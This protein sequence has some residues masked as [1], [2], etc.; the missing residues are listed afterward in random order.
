MRRLDVAILYALTVAGYPLVSAIPTFAGVDSHLASLIFRAIY[1]ALAVT[2]LIRNLRA[3][4]L[5][6]G[7]AWLP[8]G[9]FWILYTGR[10]VWDTQFSPLPHRLAG[11]EY[12]I[13]AFG[14]CLVPM[15]AFLAT[16]E[17]AT[18]DLAAT[19]SLLA[20]GLASVLAIYVSYIALTT[21]VSATYATGRLETET[22]NPVSLGH[23][24][25]STAILAAL[26]L[27][28][29][30]GAR[31]LFLLVTGVVGLFAVIASASR[32]PLLA[33]AVVGAVYLA[34]WMRNRAWQR[35]MAFSIGIVTLAT[36]LIWGAKT[37]Q[38]AF[39]L[40]T[41]DRIV[42]LHDLR[43]DESAEAHLDAVSSAWQEFL[44]RPL[45]G[46][47]ID[48]TRTSEYPHNVVVE[49]FMA[50]GVFG[51]LAFLALIALACLASINLLQS[52]ATQWVALLFVQYCVA[53]L[54]SGALY[55][56]GS[57]WCFAAA[58]IGLNAG[59]LRQSPSRKQKR[60]DVSPF[61]TVG[62]TAKNL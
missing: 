4:S 2:V 25:A 7:I 13:W 37:I 52:D 32:G 49:S 51:G 33:L 35:A 26:F 57:F 8:L 44:D 16:E 61:D 56:S 14:A 47:G 28:R 24:G 11:P 43:G 58:V 38:N 40:H 21:G 42:A 27:K 54:V 41:V 17:E 46:N 12:F 15:V 10:L 62:S 3:G 53:A 55:L 20:S 45:F 23:L 6:V 5:Y 18:S 48:E 19:L 1:F 29:W 22:L 50:T 30:K 39:G 34:N 9:L 60:V 31:R 36:V 59:H